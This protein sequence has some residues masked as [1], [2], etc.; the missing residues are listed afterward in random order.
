MTLS[1]IHPMRAEGPDGDEEEPNEE[2]PNEEEPNG[3]VFIQ[4]AAVQSAEPSGRKGAANFTMAED[5]AIS[6]GFINSTFN[7]KK[8]TEHPGKV[9]W[10]EVAQ[11]A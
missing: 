11:K 7:R 1:K 6:T 2:E 10:E 8:G 9:F 3:Y 5:Q 4:E